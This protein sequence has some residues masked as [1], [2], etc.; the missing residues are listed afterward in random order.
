MNRRIKLRENTRRYPSSCLKSIEHSQ[1]L[2]EIA[3]VIISK[4]IEDL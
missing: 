4:E 1:N 2:K 3:I